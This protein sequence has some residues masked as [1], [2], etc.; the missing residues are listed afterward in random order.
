LCNAAFIVLSFYFQ[1]VHSPCLLLLQ[2][3]F[4]LTANTV[5][6]LLRAIQKDHIQEPMTIPWREEE[7]VNLGLTTHIR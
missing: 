6:W 2:G 3:C 7:W 4:Y 1:S 5:S